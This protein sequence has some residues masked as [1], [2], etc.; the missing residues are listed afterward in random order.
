MSRTTL[1]AF[2]KAIQKSEEWLHEVMDI[3]GWDDPKHAYKALRAVLHTLRDRL[4]VQEA[5]DLAAQLPMLIRGLY[6]EGW[7]PAGKPVRIRHVDEFVDMVND[8]FSDQDLVDLYDPD[9][10]TRAVL[11]VLSGHVSAG[12]IKDII[13][14]L[15]EPLRQLWD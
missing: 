6:F 1:P 8:H 14:T 10:I 4:T 5:A 12:E 7:T 15:P 11:Q 3:L 9:D 13:A 2:Q